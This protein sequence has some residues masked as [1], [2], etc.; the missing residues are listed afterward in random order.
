MLDF[1][2][3][4]VREV[5]KFLFVGNGIISIDFEDYGYT[6]NVTVDY[7]KTSD[8]LQIISQEDCGISEEKITKIKD[9]KKKFDTDFFS[10]ISNL[11][12]IT[13]KSQDFFT[14]NVN[15]L[16]QAIKNNGYILT[17]EI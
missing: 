4:V 6:P 10:G 5:R 15:M 11:L 1:N 12:D 13:N 2:V 14:V 9:F 17:H 8:I 16:Y 3:E 7:N